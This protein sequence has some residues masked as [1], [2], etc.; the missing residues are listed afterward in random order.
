MTEESSLVLSSR[1]RRDDGTET[2]ELGWHI[3]RLLVIIDS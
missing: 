2:N 3:G 1:K